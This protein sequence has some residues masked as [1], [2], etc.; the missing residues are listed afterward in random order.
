MDIKP[1]R[2]WKDLAGKLKGQT[3]VFIGMTDVGKTTLVGYILKE[4][5][6]M[7]EA[8]SLVDSDIGQS[9]LGLPGTV[10]MKTF[11][12]PE[13]LGDFK[14]ERM[15]FIGT[16]NPA[17]KITPVV[18]AATKMVRAARKAGAGTVLVDTTGLVLGGL[19][20]ALK[21]A[22]IAA[23]RPDSV[24]AVKRADELE[25]IVK[26]LE[27]VRVFRVKASRLAKERTAAVRTKYRQG[28]FREYF[29]GSGTL[30]VRKSR[31][32]FLFDSRAA[33]ISCIEPGTLVALNRRDETLALGILE[34]TV[35]GRAAFTT[36]LKSARG[37][38]RVLIG[39]ILLPL[40]AGPLPLHGQ[41]NQ[42]HLKCMQK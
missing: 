8:V 1:Q 10:S 35:E 16:T 15:I 3:V 28:R 20:R 2:W 39:D 33:D 31:V 13:D 5:L 11:K 9:S 29:K 6:S 40:H 24:V 23:I 36:P 27:D 32:E 30:T 4:L 41:Q 21:L 17:L 18:M 42:K 37:V 38:S 26:G 7:G 34:G 12:V 22:K 25:H 19:G 14:P